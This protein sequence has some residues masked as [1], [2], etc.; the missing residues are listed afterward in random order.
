M[1]GKKF[2]AAAIG[3]TGHFD[4]QGAYLGLAGGHGLHLPYQHLPEVE[5][6][7]VADR[8]PAAAEAGRQQAGAQRAYTDFRQMLQVERP[9]IVSVCSRHAEFHEEAI[10]AAAEAGAHIY[11]DKPFAPDLA[12]ADRIIAACERHGVRLGVAHQSRYVEPWLTARVML[13]RGD[14]GRLLSITVRGKEDHR[15]GGEDLICCGVHVLDAMRMFAG[16]PLW[17]TGAVSVAGRPAEASDAYRPLDHNGPAL[18]DAAFGTF[19]FANGVLGH[20]ISRRN[21]QHRG[22]RWGLTLVGT[23]GVLSLRYGDY[24]RRTTLKLSTS[25]TVPEEA[26][27][28][29]AIET[30]FE[31]VV[32]GAAELDSVHMPTRGNRLAVWDL[33]TGTDAPRASG[34]DG[35]WTIEM[36]HGI[37]AA[38]LAGRRLALPLASRA[39]PLAA[40]APVALAG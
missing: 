28:F 39:H 33:L 1:T 11:V 4:K 27:D 32:P 3:N 8:D 7:A 31:P 5:M 10:V 2:R 38:H 30:P 40:P 15:G 6:V 19:G 18:G 16:D 20:A 9:D 29:V 26:A 25:R 35:R 34:R 23:D 36:V 13:D 22:D 37:Y 24:D 17:V 12:T 14:I 21:Q